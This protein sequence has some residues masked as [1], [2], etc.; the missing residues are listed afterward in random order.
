MTDEETYTVTV[1]TMHIIEVQRLA[2]ERPIDIAIVS[3]KSYD[4]EWCATLIR[5]YLSDQGYVVSAQNSDVSV[6]KALKAI[7]MARS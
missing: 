5:P 7:G 3:C 1:P 6:R 2:K 4:T